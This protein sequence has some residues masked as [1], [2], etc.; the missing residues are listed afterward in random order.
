MIYNELAEAKAL[1]F[2]NNAHHVVNVD[3]IV[4]SSIEGLDIDRSLKVAIYKEA[5]GI[6]SDV[7]EA[8]AQD[9][10]NDLINYGDFTILSHESPAEVLEQVQDLNVYNIRSLE[11][12]INQYYD[13]FANLSMEG[14]AQHVAFIDSKGHTRVVRPCLLYTSPSPRDNR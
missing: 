8:L 9:T 12:D 6:I 14:N 10:G 2:E 1:T 7:Y 5:R 13:T 4:A 3:N 11:A